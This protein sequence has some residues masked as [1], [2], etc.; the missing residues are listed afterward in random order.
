MTDDQFSKAF[1]DIVPD[2]PSPDG[3][4]DGAL[5]KRRNRAGV[6]GGTVGV[7]AVALAIPVALNLSNTQL[8]AGPADQEVAAGEATPEEHA[9]ED[10]VGPDPAANGLPG[11]AACYD[12]SGA[13]VQPIEG[14]SIATGATRA[15]LCGDASGE[16][17]SGTVGPVDPLQFGV[18][19][20]V[21]FVEA[22]EEIDITTISCTADYALTY[23]V[24]LEYPDG[25]VKAVSGELHGCRMLF[26]GTTHRFGGEEFY[27][28]VRGLWTEQRDS[29]SLPDFVMVTP[30]C[31]VPS[32]MLVPTLDQVHAAVLC[33]PGTE[34]NSYTP[35]ELD[36]ADVELIVDDIRANAVEGE[37]S[38][39]DSTLALI[40]SW[41]D[42]I[43]LVASD[44]D[45]SYWFRDADG[46]SWVWTPS[47]EAAD[48]L[49]AAMPD[50]PSNPIEPD[51]T[52]SAPTMPVDPDP[53]N[54]IFEPDGTVDN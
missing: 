36:P 35:T 51:E 5:R 45:D 10:G 9:P 22:Q 49:T 8:T 32:T 24:V 16:N 40:G 54:E 44:V 13:L 28:Y 26:D 50:L 15:W 17:P 46:V 1:K 52:R 18:D 20:I 2:S 6:V 19:R 39:W 3:W 41:G 31:P 30:P 37:A 25:S 34:E 42:W 43:T 27:D 12:E 21:E 14:E 4:A 11:A 33:V 47:P 48:I 23:N 7:L 29:M 38:G 53:T